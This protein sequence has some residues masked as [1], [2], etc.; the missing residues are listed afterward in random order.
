[1]RGGEVRERRS[2]VYTCTVMLRYVTCVACA[3][4][5]SHFLGSTA[6]HSVSDR[7]KPGEGIARTRPLHRP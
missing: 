2:L 7:W 6:R 3:C 5:A 4:P 1:M